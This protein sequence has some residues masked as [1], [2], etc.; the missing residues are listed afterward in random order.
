MQLHPAHPWIDPAHAPVYHL[1]Y[2]AYDAGDPRQLAQ[3][4]AD[5]TALYGTLAEWTRA[6]RRAYGFTVDLGQIGASTA[7]NR[8]RAIE[9]MEKVRQRGSPYLA[10]RAFV[11]PNEAIRGIMTAV[12]WRAPPDYP[13]QLFTNVDEARRWALEQTLALDVKQTRSQGR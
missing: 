11:T 13:F 10:C 8:Q 9:Y 1:A 2:P 6:R 4:V 5:Q 7:L 12:F 3:Y